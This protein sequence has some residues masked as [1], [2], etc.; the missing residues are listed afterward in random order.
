MRAPPRWVFLRVNPDRRGVTEIESVT[1]IF[2][3]R[4]CIFSFN[5]TLPDFTKME[6][7]TFVQHIIC[8]PKFLIKRSSI[9]VYV[10]AY[11]CPFK[12]F[13]LLGPFSCLSSKHNGQVQSSS[14]LW[15]PTS[16]PPCRSYY[17][18]F[19]GTLFSSIL[20]LFTLFDGY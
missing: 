19:S 18:V 1:Q 11:I 7:L 8:W 12:C 9:Y 5:F 10:Y 3:G 17:N 15:L 20:R 14:I 2:A 4:T 13:A 6:L 16:F